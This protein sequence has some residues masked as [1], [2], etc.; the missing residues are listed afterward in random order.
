[1]Y[2]P[3]ILNHVQ[4]H[5]FLLLTTVFSADEGL[6]CGQMFLVIDIV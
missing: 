6:S 2:P 3:H 1:M 4:V 5:S